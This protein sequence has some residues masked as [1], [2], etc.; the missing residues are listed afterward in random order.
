MKLSHLMFAAVMTVASPALAQSAATA[1]KFDVAAAKQR[2]D[3]TLNEIYPKL[4]SLYKDIHQHAEIGFQETRTAALLAS[5]MRALGFEVTEN[6]GKTGVVAIYKNG[7]GPVVLVRTELDGL[8]LEEKTGLPYASRAQQTVNGQ[9]TFISHMCGHDVHMAWWIGTA[10]TL[11]AMKDQWRGT[12]MFIAQPAEET[13]LGAKA[14][15]QDGLFK[16][17]PKPDFGFAAHVDPIPLGTVR[18]KEGPYSSASDRFH[19]IFNGRGGHAAKPNEVIDPIV[20]GARFVNDVQTVISREKDPQEFGVITV[21]SFQSG[22][23]RNIV[24]DTAELLLSVRSYSP[25]VRKLLVDGVTR[26]AKAVAMMAR[27]PE[28]TINYSPSVAPIINDPGLARQAAGVMAAAFGSDTVFLPTSAPGG[29][30]SEDFSE[31]IE[32]GVPSV[33]FTIGASDPAQLAKAKSE[34]TLFPGNH[35]PFFAPIPEPSIKRGAQTLA[36]AVLMVTSGHA[37]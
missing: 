26:T 1:P 3:A 11:V 14:M 23:A 12:L 15:L 7:A 32:Q 17:F 35:S 18:V 28:P 21:G 5:N 25:E 9:P 10:Q 22:S 31:F 29:P 2:I 33:V 6:V 16:R 30:F 37:R 36:L 27:A 34:G 24:P 19:I 8:P 13:A 20:M 4:F